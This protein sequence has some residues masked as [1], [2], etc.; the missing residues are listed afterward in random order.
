MAGREFVISFLQNYLPSYD[1]A[2]HKLYISTITETATVNV[3]VPSA[4]YQQ[5]ITVHPLKSIVVTLPQK[6]ELCASK[7]SYK[8][9]LIEATADVS[10]TSFSYK[11]YTADISVVYPT[12]SW[13]TE[14]LILTPSGS[15]RGTYKE[16]SVTNGKEGNKIEIY[17]QGNVQFEKKIYRKGQKLKVNLLPYQALEIQSFYDLTNT[18]IVSKMPVAVITGHSCTNRF[19][20]CNHV[21]EQLLPVSAWGRNIIVPPIPF[22]TKFDS[23]YIQASQN[24]KVQISLGKKT[25]TINMSS[26]SVY[27]LEQKSPDTLSIQANRGIQ[28]LLLFNGKSFGRR[29]YYDPFL[30]N[31]LSK[32]YFCTSYLLLPLPG[33]TNRVLIVANKNAAKKITFPTKKGQW[34][35]V[36]RTDFLWMD[37]S[38]KQKNN[39]IL[40]SSGSPFGLYSVGVGQMNGYGSAG[41]CIASGKV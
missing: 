12:K 7:K 34:A 21:Y 11:R 24:T 6:I 16:F 41:H 23:V 27:K 25:K 17:L 14:Y 10:I 5:K 1:I 18:R 39:Q 32:E 19:A 9:V 33:F 13:G 26:W 31:M 38:V 22:Q 29:Q 20:K 28:V 37:F 8:T 35:P 2:Q 3:Q 36:K 15:P 40:S 4:K 30:I